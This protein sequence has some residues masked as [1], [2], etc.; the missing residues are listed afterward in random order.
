[1]DRSHAE[2]LLGIYL[3]FVLIF[4]FAG[5]AGV[6]DLSRSV[7]VQQAKRASNGQ[8]SMAEGPVLYSRSFDL[9]S[10]G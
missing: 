1:M 7:E 4:G 5:V 8:N 9:K 10:L 3:R 6:R 2:I